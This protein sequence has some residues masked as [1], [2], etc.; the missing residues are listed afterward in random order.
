MGLATLYRWRTAHFNDSRRQVRPGVFVG[1]KDAAGVPDLLLAR[2]RA[3]FA[4]LK[5]DGGKPS[6]VQVAWLDALHRA[7]IECYLWRPADLQEVQ[8]VLATRWRFLPRGD[9]ATFTGRELESPALITTDEDKVRLFRPGSL[10][11]GGGRAD[12]ERLA[13]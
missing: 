7:G 10:W 4:E 13:A 1:D 5:Q 6:E 11:V 9:R 12:Q 8:K 2:E 3:V